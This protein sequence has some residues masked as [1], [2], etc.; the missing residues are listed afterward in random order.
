MHYQTTLSKA[1]VPLIAL[2]VFLLWA[3][4]LVIWFIYLRRCHAERTWNLP[5]IWR[6]GL[7]L[8]LYVVMMGSIQSLAWLAVPMGI[9]P[10]TLSPFLGDV[11][12]FLGAWWWVLVPIG[13]AVIMLS[14]RIFAS[15]R[16]RPTGHR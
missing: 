4:S 6:G 12:L 5:L 14:D 9:S 16:A 7:L 2:L 1:F 15:S 13:G 10:S 8:L 3:C 11:A